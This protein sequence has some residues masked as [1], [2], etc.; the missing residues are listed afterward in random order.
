M[1]ARYLPLL[2]ASEQPC[3]NQVDL[4]GLCCD[5]GQVNEN[6]Q[7]EDSCTPPKVDDEGICKCP[8]G[9]NDLDGLCCDEGLVNNNGVCAD[10]ITRTVGASVTLEKE[11]TSTLSDPNSDEFKSLKSEVEGG[12]KGYYI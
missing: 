5:E 4:D 12:L 1:H 10:S 7:C 9:Q 6:G 2:A 8:P 11:F 3:P